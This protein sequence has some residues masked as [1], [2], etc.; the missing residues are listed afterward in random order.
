MTSAELIFLW[1]SALTVVVIG[2]TIYVMTALAGLADD[3]NDDLAAELSGDTLIQL[4]E[5]EQLRA[6]CGPRW[7]NRERQKVLAEEYGE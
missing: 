4:E 7:A 1:L 2:L 6:I 5:I 3:T